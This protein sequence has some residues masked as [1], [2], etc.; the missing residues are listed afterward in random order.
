MDEHK[1]LTRMIFLE[2]VAGVPVSLSLKVQ[3]S[4]ETDLANSP[5]QPGIPHWHHISSHHTPTMFH[6]VWLVACGAISGRCAR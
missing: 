1:W 5:A 2:S 6:R 3:L 4:R